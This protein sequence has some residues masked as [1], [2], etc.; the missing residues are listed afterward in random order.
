MIKIFIP[1]IKGKQKTSVR[2]FWYSQDTKKT[3]YDYLKIV[4]TSYIESKQLEYLKTK[5]NQECIAY[6]D[7]ATE[8][9]KFYYSQDKIEILS[10]RIYA[11]VKNLRAEIKEALKLYG[12]VTIYK[13]GNK[14]FKEIYYNRENI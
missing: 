7:T 13:V 3:Y 14:Y 9:L 11:E 1:A 4:N 6:I 12:G 2:G 5:Y 10:N 8:C